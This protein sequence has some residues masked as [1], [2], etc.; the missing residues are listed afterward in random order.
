MLLS[1]ENIL[2]FL[3]RYELV[4]QMIESD[5]DLVTELTNRNKE[6]EVEKQQL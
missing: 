5:K 2:D 3:E 4:N 1:S 6:I